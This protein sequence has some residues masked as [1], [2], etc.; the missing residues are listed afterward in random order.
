M[1]EYILI[2]V[3]RK[4]SKVISR[5]QKSPTFWGPLGLQKSDWK[6]S[7]PKKQ[8]TIHVQKSTKH[9]FSPQLVKATARYFEI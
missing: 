8:V 7:D 5:A 1:L 3:Y 4:T 2:D 6:K 9:D